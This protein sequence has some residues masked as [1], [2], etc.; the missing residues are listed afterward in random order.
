MMHIK[1]VI[2]DAAY[3]QGV[4]MV[5]STMSGFF[6][7]FRIFRNYAALISHGKP[8]KVSWCRLNKEQRAR[9]LE[10]ARVYGGE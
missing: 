9:A 10:L 6:N 8:R 1:V 2:E 7:I 5:L 4:E 3:R